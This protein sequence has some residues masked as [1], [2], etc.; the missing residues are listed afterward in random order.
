MDDEIYD[1]AHFEVSISGLPSGMFT[2]LELYDMNNSGSLETSISGAGSLSVTFR[3][4]GGLFGDT[5]EDDW[6]VRIYTS[7]W[8]AGACTSNYTLEIQSWEDATWP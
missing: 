7:N 4:D 5:G 8:N 1:N 3:G 2:V 6:A